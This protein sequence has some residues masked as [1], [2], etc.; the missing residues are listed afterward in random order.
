MD[1]RRSACTPQ[2]LYVATATIKTALL[3]VA[4]TTM[5]G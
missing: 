5:H 2:I 1:L 4:C 3:N